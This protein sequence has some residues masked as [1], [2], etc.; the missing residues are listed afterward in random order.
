MRRY[1][2]SRSGVP[3]VRTTAR[4]WGEQQIQAFEA[5]CVATG[6]LPHELVSDM[7]LAE[8]HEAV[9]TREF[10]QLAREGR[11]WRRGRARERLAAP[12]LTATAPA[13]RSRRGLHPRMVALTDQILAAL[14]EEG[15]LPISTPALFRKLNEGQPEPTVADVLDLAH[16]GTLASTGRVYYTDLLR[17]LNRL[18]KLGEVEKIKLEDMRFV[19]WRRLQAGT[20]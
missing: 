16:T 8:L 18:A 14:T 2:D 20:A 1:T 4:I 11:D 13:A 7:V 17:M 15:P 3:W 9:G 6:R 12:V 5:M 19:Y 10:R